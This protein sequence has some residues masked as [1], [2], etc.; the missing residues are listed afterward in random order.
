MKV[1]H[2]LYL[3]LFIFNTNLYSQ[4]LDSK[5]MSH[6]SQIITFLKNNGE[7]NDSFSLDYY[8]QYLIS[9]EICNINKKTV[10]YQ[11]GL[12]ST[13]SK[14]FVAVLSNNKLIIY[15]TKNFAIEFNDIL[16]KLQSFKLEL[17]N[18]KLI[19]CIKDIKFLYDTN[20]TNEAQVPSV[21]NWQDMGLNTTMGYIGLEG[22]PPGAILSGIYFLGDA[23]IPGNV[24]KL[25]MTI[26]T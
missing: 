12:S 16:L 7:T 21:T 2:I 9:G 23:F 10:F 11:L 6:Q 24:S 8:K 20:Q 5:L 14:R 19:E 26:N 25:V 13:H 18:I 1:R 3:I 4:M 15:P 17:T 22:G